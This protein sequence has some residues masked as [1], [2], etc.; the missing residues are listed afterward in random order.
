LGRHGRAAENHPPQVENRGAVAVVDRRGT[1]D[2]FFRQQD[3][4]HGFT[5]DVAADAGNAKCERYFDAELDGLAQSWAGEVAWCNPPWSECGAW[6][7]KALAEVR[8]GCLGA[9]LLLPANRTE[10]GWWQDLVEPVR[11]RGLGV[12]TEFVRARLKF[13]GVRTSDAARN[14][15]ANRPPCGVVLVVVAPPPRANKKTC[16]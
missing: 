11:D 5:V 8:A 16:K 13:L 1:P 14:P 6:V 10:L 15:R 9:V 3:A 4:L 12:S 7:A 2:W